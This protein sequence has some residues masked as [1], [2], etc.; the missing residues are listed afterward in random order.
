MTRGPDD[1][2]RELRALNAL[3]TLAR[4]TVQRPSTAQL[5]R[6]LNLLFARATAY[7]SRT[8]V[9]RWSLAGLLAA[10]CTLLG[11]QLVVVLRGRVPE[12][13]AVEYRVEGGSVLAG[14]YLRDSGEDGVR[15]LFN[16]GTKV[17]LMP[18]ARG[19]LRSLDKEGT[20]VV[21]DQGTASFDV[22]RSKDR[23]WLVEAG[24]FSVAVKGTLFTVSWDP[25]SER[26]ELRLQHGSVVVSGPI[27]SGDIELRAGQR[28]LV[29]LPKAETLIIEEPADGSTPGASHASPTLSAEPDPAAPALAAGRSTAQDTPLA[30][31]S[32]AVTASSAGNKVERKSSWADDLAHGHWD[33]ILEEVE[34]R[35]V[36]TTLEAV[37]SEDLF[38]LADA[39]RYRRRT[40]LARAALLA[41]RRR[42][43]GSS[44][45]LDATFLL[46]RVEEARDK[47][48]AIGWY[49]EYLRRA[50]TGSYAAEALGRK[51]VLT[52]E[53]KGRSVARPIAEEYLRRFPKGS[54]AEAARV[55]CGEP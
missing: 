12:Q 48:R 4:D 41:Q 27:A 21:V 47:T 2:H 38:A 26:F 7:R 33:R 44:R 43:P 55:A 54:Y 25:S 50:A 23:R 42:F 16:E 14:G 46:G 31:R 39:A 22:A 17:N 20:R 32:S 36:D 51:M 13:R 6:G 8:R 52:N 29:N 53:L 24:P 30:I 11:V 1:D 34:R 15:L 49:D 9:V 18:G 5:A 28:L 40:D 45:S 35:G 19:R 3:T 37:T 10:V